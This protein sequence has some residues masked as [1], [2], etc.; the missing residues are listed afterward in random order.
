MQLIKYPSEAGISEIIRRPVLGREEIESRVLP[1]LEE[2]RTNGDYALKKFALEFDNILM[3]DFAVPVKELEEFR[4]TWIMNFGRL[5]IRL[6][7]IFTGFT[8][9]R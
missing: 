7:K 6:L 8:G 2:V 4:P 3:D 5:L 9:P 1:V